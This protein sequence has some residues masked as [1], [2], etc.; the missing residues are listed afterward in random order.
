[1]KDRAVQELVQHAKT[2]ITFNL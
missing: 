1:V 2:R